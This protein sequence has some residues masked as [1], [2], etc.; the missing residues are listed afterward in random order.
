MIFVYL[1]LYKDETNPS[2]FG[3]ITIYVYFTCIQVDNHFNCLEL[4]LIVNFLHLIP[5]ALPFR[6]NKGLAPFVNAF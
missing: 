4:E 5:L 1:S 2:R 6:C 3:G